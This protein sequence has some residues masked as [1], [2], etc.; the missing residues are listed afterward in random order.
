MRATIQKLFDAS[1]FQQT[2]QCGFQLWRVQ[3]MRYLKEGMHLKVCR[4]EDLV[5]CTLGPP[6]LEHVQME[7]EI[8]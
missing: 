3:V 7:R 2:H 1:L 6:A 5:D 4:I 8:L